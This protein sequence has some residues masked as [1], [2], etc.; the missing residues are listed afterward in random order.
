MSTTVNREL[1]MPVIEEAFFA[2]FNKISLFATND[3][4]YVD[5]KQVHIPQSGTMP[6]VLKNNSSYPL[7]VNDRTD[8]I[9]TYD[10]DSWQMPAVRI[11]DFDTKDLSYDLQKSVIYNQVGNLGETIMF[12]LINNFYIGKE[13]DKYV[14]TSGDAAVAQAPGATGQRKALTIEDLS[15]AAEILDKQKIPGSERFLILPPSMFYQLHSSM[16][17]TYTINDNDGLT[18]MTGKP[19]GFTIISLPQV[20]NTTSA[21]NIRAY[22]HSGATSDLECG[23]ALHKSAVSIARKEIK[24]YTNSADAEYQA[25]IISAGTWAGGKYRREDKKGVVPILQDSI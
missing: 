7:S 4:I 25:D 15:K 2:D 3:D 6:T 19:M 11:G 8:T 12:N 16:I 10:I 23:L 5:S 18:M 20:I 13:T 17:D 9:L 14:E 24:I 22:G 1:W 21:G